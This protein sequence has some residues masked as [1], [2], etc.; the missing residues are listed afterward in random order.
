MRRCG[1]ILGAG[2]FGGA[3][4]AH[5]PV[6]DVGGQVGDGFQDGALLGFAERSAV[7]RAGPCLQGGEDLPASPF[8]RFGQ[9]QAAE[10]AGV[11]RGASC[12]PDQ[13]SPFPASSTG[14]GVY[15]ASCARGGPANS[16]AASRIASAG[17]MPSPRSRS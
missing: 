16:G 4:G 13:V 11:W 7:L 12:G 6:D 3:V 15:G 17:P 5:D 9:S 1:G 10:F 2:G 14:R 8:L